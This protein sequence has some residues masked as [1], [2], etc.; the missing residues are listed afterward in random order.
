MTEP[1]S[2]LGGALPPLRDLQ[3]DEHELACLRDAVTPQAAVERL[4]AAGHLQTAARLVAQA[5]P[6]R[7]AVWW[8]CMCCR[9]VPGLQPQPARLAWLG[10]AELWVRRPVEETRRSCVYFDAMPDLTAPEGWAAMGAFWSGG[11]VAPETAANI[12]A[13]P[14]LTAA[15]VEAAVLL[16]AMRD[17]AS[18]QHLARLGRFLNAARDIALGGAGRLTP[19]GAA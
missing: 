17:G 9:A 6:K 5:L 7:E 4:E 8:A 1:A 13:G 19:E 12:P 11:S 2:K 3:L 15:A 18:M 10:A 16:A 14:G